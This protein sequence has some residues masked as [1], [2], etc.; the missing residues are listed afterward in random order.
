MARKG[1]VHITGRWQRTL[2]D[3]ARCR[4]VGTHDTV[5]SHA[6]ASQASRRRS[7]GGE[8][9]VEH[10]APRSVGAQAKHAA[11][12][13]DARHAA[14]PTHVPVPHAARV[15]TLGRR[16]MRSARVPCTAQLAR[17]TTRSPRTRYNPR[18]PCNPRGRC[19]TTSVTR[20][21]ERLADS[22]RGAR[23]EHAARRGPLG[24]HH[25]SALMRCARRHR[26]GAQQVANAVAAAA[27]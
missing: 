7:A 21:I 24:S 17:R 6:G 22:M 27:D 10:L 14:R 13:T 18:S 4:S 3:I 5:S 12:P 20:G 16:W 1:P 11:C 23:S 25:G 19:S 15:N 2:G 8:R 9:R 26:V